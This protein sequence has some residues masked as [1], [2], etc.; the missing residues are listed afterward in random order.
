MS[1]IFKIE[2]INGNFLEDLAAGIGLLPIVQIPI[3]KTDNE[4]LLDELEEHG[5]PIPYLTCHNPNPG[6]YQRG[7]SRHGRT[8]AQHA[9]IFVGERNAKLIRMKHPDL[10]MPRR[11][12]G[13]TTEAGILPRVPAAVKENELI[14]SQMQI[15]LNT[16]RAAVGD[17]E[18]VVAFIR[19]WTYSQIDAILYAAYFLFGAPYDIFEIANYIWGWVPN[20]HALKACS[21]FTET[22]LEGRDPNSDAENLPMRGDRDINAWLRLHNVDPD[23]CSP[24]DVGKYL[25]N[26]PA[27]RPVAFNCSLE[28]ARA[29]I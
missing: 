3:V 1:D 6:F 15:N 16:M 8:W 29:K 17:G 5:G 13:V 25:F 20:P 21:T 2:I 10:M 28:D 26:A 11:I 27:Y 14:E 4:K 23:R 18:Q 9:G 12:P 24:G 22:A 7:I 19:D